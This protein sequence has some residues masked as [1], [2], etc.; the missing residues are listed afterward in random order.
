MPFTP[1]HFGPGAAIKAIVPKQFSFTIFCFS[2][3]VTDF[4]TLYFM[5]RGAHPLHQFFH[6]CV[7]ATFVGFFSVFAGRPIC[8]LAL[9]IWSRSPHMPFKEFFPT[10]TVI[11]W[12]C[13]ATGALIGTYSHVFLDSIMHGDTKPLMPF[14]DANPLYMM[15]GPGTLHLICLIFGL[16]GA[17]CIARRNRSA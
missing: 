8:Q 9:R 5:A 15:V 7:G 2:Q 1:F 17:F 6:T 10:E 4:E 12:H 13:A 3:V 11:P 14:S 16:A